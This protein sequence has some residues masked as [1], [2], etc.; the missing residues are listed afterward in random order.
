MATE[1][2]PTILNPQSF[3]GTTRRFDGN[4][5]SL[6][7]NFA[8]RARIAVAVVL[9]FKRNAL[10]KSI[11]ALSSARSLA[12]F[13]SPSSKDSEINSSEPASSGA[14]GSIGMFRPFVSGKDAS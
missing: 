12:N 4:I 9:C 2:G 8:F 14:P 5:M 3:S 13:E 1:T 11:E 6:N 10:L 7:D